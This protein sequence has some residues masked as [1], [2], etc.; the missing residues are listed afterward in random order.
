MVSASSILTTMTVHALFGIS[1]LV[2]LL[3]GGHTG[4]GYPRCL[5]LRP[6]WRCYRPNKCSPDLLLG[7]VAS[8]T[9]TKLQNL[10]TLHAFSTTP[11]RRR[12]LSRTSSSSSSNRIYNAKAYNNN[13]NTNANTNTNNAKAKTKTKAPNTNDDHND[14]VPPSSSSSTSNM[15]S[16][17]SNPAFKGPIPA[18]HDFHRNQGLDVKIG[19]YYEAKQTLTVPTAITVVNPQWTTA[20]ML[21]TILAHLAYRH[22]PIR[23]KEVIESLEFYCRVRK[24]LLSYA[25][26]HH[27]NQYPNSNSNKNKNTTTT[28]HNADRR[29]TVHVVDA[30]AG[31]GFTGL[32]FAACNPP[33]AQRNIRTTLIDIE[34]H[35]SHDILKAMI[36]EV[37]PW[38]IAAN[39]TIAKD[40]DSDP[41]YFYNNNNYP[42]DKNHVTFLE[43]PLEVFS[44]QWQDYHTTNN[45]THSI[46][47]SNL[48]S[49]SHPNEIEMEN[50][51]TE[52]SSNVVNLV[53][54][55][56]ACGHLSDLTLDLGIQQLDAAGIA[57]MPCCYRGANQ[58]TRNPVTTE[59]PYGVKQVFGIA[60]GADI[61]R[62]TYLTNHQYQTDF[63]AIPSQI[64]PM[65][66]IIVGEK[67]GK[68]RR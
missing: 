26:R 24:R 4:R 15:L 43:M 12:M 36:A 28:T 30:C 5:R 49:T 50:R 42:T 18:L 59:I 34:K 32:L 40:D 14:K 37:C 38:M 57:I 54:A 8:L 16:F 3:F 33:T 29:Y 58:F 63:T 35:Q 17:N 41:N 7:M 60:W 11:T 21:H 27:Q 20:R 67:L 1:L 9:I 22:A 25:H 68:K 51:S 61:Y 13:N 6:R 2:T 31:H 62:A 47:V 46:P 44:Q 23:M 53:I 66:R 64:T 55:T 65:N 56:H 39:T 45:E 52:A 19:R 48:S 10:K